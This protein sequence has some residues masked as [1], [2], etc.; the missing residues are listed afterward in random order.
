MAVL[1]L[2]RLHFLVENIT[3]LPGGVSWGLALS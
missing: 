2:T 3:L 1:A